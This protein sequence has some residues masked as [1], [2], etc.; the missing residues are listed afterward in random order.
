MSSGHELDI[1]LH[2]IIHTIVLDNKWE[3]INSKHGCELKEWII[4]ARVWIFLNIENENSM[5]S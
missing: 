5:L 1:L 2:N 3:N 4:D